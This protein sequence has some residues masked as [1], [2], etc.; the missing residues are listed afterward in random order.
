MW[1]TLFSE[2]I[3]HRD[4]QIPQYCGS[5]V[6]YDPSSFTAIRVLFSRMCVVGSHIVRSTLGARRDEGVYP[7]L[8]LTI[9][10]VEMSTFSV[11][12]V[13]LRVK[14]VYTAEEPSLEPTNGKLRDRC[15][16]GV[17]QGSDTFQC[18]PNS[19]GRK[20]EESGGKSGR[21]LERMVRPKKLCL[22]TLTIIA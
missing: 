4:M 15:L 14:C 8:P 11:V 19:S 7:I 9:L 3:I 18:P 6:K 22:L 1:R 5:L 12:F 10:F 21:E 13:S 17:L 16:N 2:P 20:S